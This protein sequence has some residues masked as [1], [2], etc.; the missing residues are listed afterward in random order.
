MET[1]VFARILLYTAENNICKQTMEGTKVISF[2]VPMADYIKLLTQA[3]QLKMSL[4]DY[5]LMKVYG[6]DGEIKATFKQSESAIAAVNPEPTPQPPTKTSAPAEEPP[7]EEKPAGARKAPKKK[8]QATTEKP[9]K[10]KAKSSPTAKSKKPARASKKPQM[11]TKK[12][13]EQQQLAGFE[14]EALELERKLKEQQAQEAEQ[15]RLED[16][17]RKAEELKQK[18][19][20]EQERQRLEEIESLKGEFEYNQTKIK[21]IKQK[22]VG[23]VP[24]AGNKPEREALEKAEIRQNEIR[25]RITQLQAKG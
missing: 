11:D 6:P 10:V 7:K 21:I 23:L 17:K 9:K 1:N 22:L 25:N 2:R 16:A 3:T 24:T 8:A 15:R 19:E 13:V 14:N 5:V 20:K 18:L 4:S 12:K